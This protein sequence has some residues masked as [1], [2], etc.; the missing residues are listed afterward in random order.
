M[1]GDAITAGLIVSII[2]LS[3][4]GLW[5]AQAYKCSAKQQ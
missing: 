3:L 4:G 1:S 5:D 2:L